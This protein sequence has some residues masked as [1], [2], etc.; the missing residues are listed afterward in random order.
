MS[1]NSSDILDELFSVLKDRKRNPPENSYT[2]KLYSGGEEKIC[3]KITEEAGELVEAAFESPSPESTK[4]LVH[5]AAD[6]WFHTMVLMVHK[7]VSL[8]DIRSELGRRFGISGLDEK[9]SRQ[10]SQSD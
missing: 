4:H 5:E 3:E 2:S 9:A 10:Q 1:D 8:D 6:L 7:G